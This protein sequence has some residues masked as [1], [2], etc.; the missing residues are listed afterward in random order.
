MKD[1]LALLHA[2]IHPFQGRTLLDLFAR[3][4]RVLARRA[5]CSRHLLIELSVQQWGLMAFPLMLLLGGLAFANLLADLCKAL[6]EW[7]IPM[8]GAR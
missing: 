3:K 5:P 6:C 7:P 2:L 1:K 4:V 8:N